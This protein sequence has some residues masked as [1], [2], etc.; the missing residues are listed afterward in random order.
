MQSGRAKSTTRANYFN[1]ITVMVDGNPVPKCV[2]KI[3]NKTLALNTDAFRG[4]IEM[5]E[6][7]AEIPELLQHLPHSPSKYGLLL[8]Y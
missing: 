7:R 6:N 4:H 3:C 1:D 5:H 8:N 2:C